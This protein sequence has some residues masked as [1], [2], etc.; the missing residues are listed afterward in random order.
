[1]RAEISGFLQQL[2]FEVTRKDF[3]TAA[4]QCEMHLTS[5]LETQRQVA[6]ARAELL[7][8]VLWWMGAQTVYLLYFSNLFSSFF[9]VCL[10]GETVSGTLVIVILHSVFFWG[11]CKTYSTI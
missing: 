11:V 8:G 6:E 7:A 5:P 4:L 1:M 3:Y 9:F 2:R 10:K